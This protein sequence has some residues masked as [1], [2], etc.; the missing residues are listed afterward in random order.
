[1]RS[2]QNLG[3]F[4]AAIHNCL[5]GGKMKTKTIEEYMESVWAT[6]D[7]M[8]E[9]IEESAAETA[10]RQ[11][12]LEIELK[13]Q[14][15]A[16]KK[17]QDNLEIELKLRKNEFDTKITKM[18]ES[19]GH[20]S[21]NI[22]YIAE[23]YFFNSFKAGKANFFGEDFDRIEKNVK[24]IKINF[25][26]EYD[27]LLINGHTIGIV[28][29]KSK[30]H[31]NDISK[32]LK[33]AETFRINFPDYQNHKVYLGLASMAFYDELETMCKL[34]GIAII[35]QVGETLIIYDDN[36]KSY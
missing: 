4:C 1:M 29:V 6:L 31:T 21:N 13:K 33:K 28:E 27:I 32:V 24:G 25:K 10:K 3:A 16:A 11:K 34:N 19:M 7:R 17:R 23:E 8:A 15:K 30:A 35:K 5:I 9:R 12:S 14:Q 2:L 26:D 22:G 20:Y 18:N 36:I